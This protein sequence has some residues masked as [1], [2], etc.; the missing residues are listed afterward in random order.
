VA[1]AERRA[2]VARAKGDVVDRGDAAHLGRSLN[3]LDA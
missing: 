2:E 1:E 3:V